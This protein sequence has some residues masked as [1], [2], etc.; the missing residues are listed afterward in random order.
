LVKKDERRSVFV[1][2][3]VAA[4][5]SIPLILINPYG[6]HKLSYCTASFNSDIMAKLIEWS[7]PNFDSEMG[8]ITTLG[9]I[10]M[11]LTYI[12]VKG[13]QYIQNKRP[14]SVKSLLLIGGLTIL[15][16]FAIRFFAYFLL[17][18]GLVILEDLSDVNKSKAST[19]I[20]R[21]FNEKLY[22]FKDR[23]ILFIL[24]LILTSCII[25]KINYGLW[26]VTDTRFYSKKIVEYIKHNTDYK[27]IRMFNQF[28]DGSYLMFNGIKVFIDSRRDL[29]SSQLNPGCTVLS[30][31]N[32]VVDGK[33]D[34]DKFFNKYNFEY[35]FLSNYRLTDFPSYKLVIEDG[36]FVLYKKIN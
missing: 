19:K 31:Y 28:I 12:F 3:S 23:I 9:L 21:F 7:R 30:D 25:I 29:Y 33:Y 5:A 8:T 13:Y 26:K 32:L 16:C 35:I 27:N 6:Y 18:Y 2:L 14:V 15:T 4:L 17:F 36:P 22:Q 10:I 11:L 34:L 1:S 24:I 20:P